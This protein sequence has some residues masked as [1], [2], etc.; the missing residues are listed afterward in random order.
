MT[1]R[2]SP[3]EPTD[4]LAARDPVGSFA[5]AHREGRLVALHT[6]GTTGQSRRIVRTTSS[7][8]DSFPY[9]S[10]LLGLDTSSRVWIPGPLTSTMNLF[11]AVHA[12]WA[13]ATRV[14]TS[15]EATHAHLLPS[16][17]RR[18]L[19]VAPADLVD[20]H[21]LVAGDRLARST[22][23]DATAHGTR[24]SHYYGAAE[25]SFVAWG[26]HA[27]SL[28][29]FPGVE[30]VSRSGELWVRS[31]YVC[32]EYVEPDQLVRSDN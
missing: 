15:R 6:S 18:E 8:V 4:L 5:K 12:Q 32:E 24:V 22:F 14:D 31:P 21:V 9:V 13:G 11:A 25:L 10:T 1:L 26:A 29:P 23:D 2:M 20:R 30:V 7:W 19:D 27:E 28:R 16:L 17:L 3:P